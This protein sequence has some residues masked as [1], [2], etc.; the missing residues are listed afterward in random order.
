M[1]ELTLTRETRFRDGSG[2][3]MS[4]CDMAEKII[5]WIAKEPQ[6]EY[7]LAIGTDS[8]TYDE[9]KIV[10][11]VTVHRLHSGGIFFVRTMYHEAFR[12]GQLQYKLHTETQVSLDAADLLLEALL[13]RDFDITRADSNVHLTVHI[14]VGTNGPTSQYI[15]ELEGWVRAMGYD[16][17]IKPAS[18]AASTIADRCS[19]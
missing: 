3:V 5:A 13:E 8:Q 1:S 16:C 2:H 17:E 18:Y 19:K 9:T 10:L 14:D 7:V 11:A 6:K 4:F 12:K 15:R